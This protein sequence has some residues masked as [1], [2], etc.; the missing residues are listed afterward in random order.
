MLKT[1]LSRILFNIPGWRTNRK[2]LVIESDDWGSIRMPSPEVFKKCLRAG[3]PVDKIVYERYDSLASEEDLELLF[4]LLSSFKDA[5]GNHPLITA[6]SLVANPDFEKI[7][8][9]DF[10]SYHYELI[11][12]TFKKYPSHK[13]NFQIWKQGME[14]NVFRPQFHGR[15]HLNVPMFMH[16][17]QKGDRDAHF[18]FSHGMPGSIPMG[19]VVQGN[20]YVE[21]T[22]FRTAVDKDET[23]RILREGL[24]LFEKLF[25]YKSET[26]IPPNY[27]WS[28]DFNT[29]VQELGVRSFQGIRKQREPVPGGADKYHDVYMGKKNSIGQTYMIRNTVFEPSMH[30]LQIKDPVQ[31]CL[32]ELSIAFRLNK[33]AIIGSHRINYVGFLDPANR[34]TTL[35][36]LEQILSRALK[37]WP[38][39]EFMSS[40]QLGGLITDKNLAK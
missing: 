35:K 18:G 4:D 20:P 26:I 40:D 9:D 16:A 5:R 8:A 24:V 17:L 25:G 30:R 23:L 34:D 28:P 15:E 7:E 14:A 21:A 6:N 10:K 12:E 11:T 19:P 32:T 2:I 36:M 39:I 27:T 37:R 38:D 22:R 29:A 3:Y 31:H 33:P 1:Y 13:N